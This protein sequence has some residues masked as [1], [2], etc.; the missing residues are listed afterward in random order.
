[1]M[2]LSDWAGLC[3]SMNF[4]YVPHCL[5]SSLPRM[6]II[7]VSSVMGAITL[8]SVDDKVNPSSISPCDVLTRGVVG[9]SNRSHLYTLA[10]EP[11]ICVSCVRVTESF[12]LAPPV[13][14]IRHKRIS[15]VF[16][17]QEWERAVAF[18]CGAF[19]QPVLAAQL[20]KDAIQ[21]S[22]RTEDPA[23]TQAAADTVGKRTKK[24]S[25]AIASASTSTAAPAAAPYSVLPKVMAL[26]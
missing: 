19:R 25:P 14:G 24:R 6:L 10:R 13:R 12:L 23:A 11:A 21:F 16:H 4:E 26:M 22:T 15:G 9:V 17:S 20:H 7:G 5:P 18:V 1:M 2:Y 3:P 8:T